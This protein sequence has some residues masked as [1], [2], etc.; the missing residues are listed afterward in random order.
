MAPT[1]TPS[2]PK[3]AF[4]KDWLTSYGGSEEQLYQLHLLYPDAPIYTTVYDSQRL[5]QFA[6]ADIRTMKLPAFMQAGRRFEKLAPLMPGYFGRLDLAEYDVVVSVTSGFAKG[7]HTTNTTKHLCICN[8]P[9][10]MAWG[11][12]G[13]DRGV[14][15]RLLGR[16]LRSFDVKSSHDVDLF[17]ANSHNVAKRIAEV[18]KRTSRV[19]YPPVHV[20]RFDLQRAAHPKG[21]VTTSRLVPYKRV[22]ILIAACNQLRIPLTVFGVGPENDRLRKLSG[23]TI[24]F[25][26]FATAKKIAETY[27][28]SEAFLFA[29][30]E[31][32]GIALVEAMAAGCPVIAYKAGGALETVKDGVSGL[33]F[34]DQSK[35]SV[36]AALT[37]YAQHGFESNKV[38]KWAQQFS[39]QNFVSAITTEIDNALSPGF[40]RL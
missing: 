19:L 32:F 39:T 29:G 25:E 37:K 9:L 12:G 4:T 28:K 31:D 24:T 33:F 23:P 35:E 3:I 21:F 8:T 17:L 34:P 26:G 22:D 6:K 38:K 14:V 18:Y 13:D 2:R 40:T 16:L 11:F 1:K 30:E 5:P 15:G 7:I 20:D 27:S 36:V 10:R